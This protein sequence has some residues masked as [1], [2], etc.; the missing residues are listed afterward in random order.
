[1]VMTTW[2]APPVDLVVAANDMPR[3]VWRLAG[4]PVASSC[5]PGPS[6]SFVF[7]PLLCGLELINGSWVRA[8]RAFHAN[9]NFR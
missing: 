3:L 4:K 6:L 5:L 1:M 2:A 8:S 7:F 9:A